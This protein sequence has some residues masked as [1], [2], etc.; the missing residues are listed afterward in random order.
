[1]PQWP[2]LLLVHRMSAV[3]IGDGIEEGSSSDDYYQVMFIQNVET[4]EAFSSYVVLVKAEKAYT[5][6]HINIMT[7]AFGLKMAPW[8]RT[9]LYKIP[10]QS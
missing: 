6:G 3:K 9:S 4:I 2:N 8:C 7:Q 10:T 1:M 5:R